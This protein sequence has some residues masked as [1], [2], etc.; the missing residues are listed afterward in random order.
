MTTE[1]NGGQDTT[2]MAHAG[3]ERALRGDGVAEVAGGAAGVPTGPLHAGGARGDG[4]PVG[5]REARRP[6]PAVPRDR[7]EDARVDDDGDAGGALAPLR[8]RRLPARTR[9]AEARDT[10]S[11]THAVPAA[12]RLTIP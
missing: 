7:V 3:D 1:A 2:P 11:L 9:P 6:W 5:G 10:D 4:A 8:R 12:A